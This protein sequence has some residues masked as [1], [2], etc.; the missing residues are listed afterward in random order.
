MDTLLTYCGQ[1]MPFSAS[2]GGTSSSNAFTQFGSGEQN[3]YQC[4]VITLLT[5][6]QVPPEPF[7]THPSPPPPPTHT[8]HH[9]PRTAQTRAFQ[10]SRCVASLPHPPP[11]RPFCCHGAPYPTPPYPPSVQEFYELY[12]A[13]PR[14]P[15]NAFYPAPV[16]IVN[17]RAK[18]TYPNNFQVRRRALLILSFSP[19]SLTWTAS[20]ALPGETPSPSTEARIHLWCALRARPLYRPMKQRGA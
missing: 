9:T 19:R 16:R 20:S 13:D 12:L 1:R 8:A 14:A 7:Y 5:K 3:T 10:L 15:G 2:G 6:P 11:P 18:G 4:D 17:L